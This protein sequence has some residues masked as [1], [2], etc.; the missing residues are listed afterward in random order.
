MSYSIEHISVTNTKD[1]GSVSTTT[2]GAY[3]DTFDDL[4]IHVAETLNIDFIGYI[5]KDSVIEARGINRIVVAF[6]EQVHVF[7]LV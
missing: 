7:T 3:Y 1:G 6:D 5:W 4:R 2:T